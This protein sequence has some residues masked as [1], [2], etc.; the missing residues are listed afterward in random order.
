MELLKELTE[1]SGAPGFEDEIRAIVLRELKGLV[2]EVRVD[3]LGSIIAKKKADCPTHPLKKNRS[4]PLLKIMLAGHMDEIGFVVRHIDEKGFL[5]LNPLGGFDPKTLIAKRVIV[6]TQKRDLVGVIGTKPIHILTD[7]EK[8]KLPKIEDL[9]VDLGLPSKEVERSV[10]IGDPVTLKQEFLSFGDYVSCKSMD[11]RIAVWTILKCLQ[12]LKNKKIHHDL[13]AV[14]TTQEEVGTR[15]AMTSAFEV[16]PD[17][18]IAIDVTIACD[19]PE[20]KT[21]SHVTS[22]GDGVAIKVCDSSTICHP[23]LVRHFREL[24][25]KKQIKYQMEILPR[26]G[27]DAASI[28]RSRSGVPVAVLSIPTRYVHTAVETV[29][30]NDLKSTV[31]LLVAFLESKEMPD[32]SYG[33]IL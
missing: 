21:S 28:Q 3:R 17:I 19:I 1:A 27:T 18:G 15:G 9:F 30:Q 26:G 12:R 13:Y 22:L 33:K 4:H 8:A 32:I 5:R 24:A 7:E 11:N 16:D 23:T 31:E 2:D 6:R 14:F 25:A 20:V 10:C 29:H